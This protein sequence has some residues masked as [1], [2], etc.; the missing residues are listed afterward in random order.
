[1][2]TLSH[3]CPHCGIKNNAFLGVKSVENVAK[4]YHWTTLFICPSCR[5]GVVVEIAD[6]GTGIDPMSHPSEM[7]QPMQN[8][9][10]K[11][12]GIV[13]IYPKPIATEVPSHLP[14]RVAKTLREGCEILT[15][16]PTGACSLFRKTLEIALKDLSPEIE[17]WKLEK[18][19]DKMAA[20]HLITP[21]IQ[22]WAHQLRLDGNEA[23]HESEDPTIDDARQMESLTRF[24]LM[25]VY[26]LPGQIAEARQGAE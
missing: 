15:Q 4:K 20:Q 1:M 19:I 12:F 2:P 8:M 23:L 10:G 25:Y 7:R 5:G 22:E 16:S 26:T 13:N 21:S 24:V 14:E 18:R 3:D 17:A 11:K 6:A 9:P